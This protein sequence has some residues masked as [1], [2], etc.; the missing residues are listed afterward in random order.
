MQNY[1]VE[2]RGY[3]S[4]SP[5]IITLTN[6]I[7]LSPSSLGLFSTVIILIKIIQF[8]IQTRLVKQTEKCSIKQPFE[9][10]QLIFINTRTFISRISN[11]NQHDLLNK[12]KVIWFS[13]YTFKCFETSR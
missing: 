1:A 4:S 7:T 12:L 8:M 9:V 11:K 5:S 2:L 13:M 6:D 3:S 10:K